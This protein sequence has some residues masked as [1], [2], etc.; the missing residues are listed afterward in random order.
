M[1]V[2]AKKLEAVTEEVQRFMRTVKAAKER[3]KEDPMA[4]CG[5]QE[6]GAVRRASMDLT[7]ALVQ[8]RK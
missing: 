4:E 6:T 1:G 2:S 5:S 3:L 8:L 7:R